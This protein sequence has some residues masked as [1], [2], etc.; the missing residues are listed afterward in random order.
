MIENVIASILDAEKSAGE[1]LAEGMKEYKKIIAEAESQ[2]DKEKK[3]LI[4][5]LKASQDEA[6]AKAEQKANANYEK[7]LEDGKVSAEKLKAESLAK[8]DKAVSY[9]IGKVI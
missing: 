4:A 1:I 8:T 6:F 9:I 2:V 5:S 3:E 7:T